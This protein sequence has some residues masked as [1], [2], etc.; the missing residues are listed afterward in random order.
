MNARLQ[1]GVPAL[2]P[3][4]CSRWSRLRM[5]IPAA[6][7]CGTTLTE[8]LIS[9]LVIGIGV[10]SV[11]TLFPLSL[12]RA[13]RATQLTAAA[14]VMQNALN[15]VQYSYFPD[16]GIEGRAMLF[17]PDNNGN[18]DRYG[19]V[20]A[21]GTPLDF[22]SGFVRGD[23]PWQTGGP[24]GSVRKY[25]VDP[26]GAVVLVDRANT[27]G[28]DNLVDTDGDGMDDFHPLIFG[29]LSDQDDVPLG[30]AIDGYS[31][32]F[33]WPA[34]GLTMEAM[35]TSAPAQELAIAQ[36]NRLVGKGGSYET[37]FDVTATV[38]LGQDLEMSNGTLIEFDPRDASGQA[39]ES[40]D[41]TDADDDTPV[42]GDGTAGGVPTEVVVYSDDGRSS[43]KLNV[44]AAQGSSL[45]AEDIPGEGFA[46]GGLRNLLMGAAADG[47]T[48]VRRVLLRVEEQRY[49][50]MLT[51]RRLGEGRS[52]AA[53][54]GDVVVFFNRS[55]S[56]EDE[57]VWKCE[58]D[59]DERGYVVSL[60]TRGRLPTLVAGTHFMDAETMSW[61]RIG[62]VDVRDG[63]TSAFFTLPELRRVRSESGTS[64]VLY[65]TFM[66][67]VV[68]VYPFQEV[69]D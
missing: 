1:Y 61:Y 8:V 16:A 38:T 7:R 24:V 13:A 58:Y 3:G 5:S 21:D 11:A 65:A 18:V 9:L 26:L 34:T 14:G 54:A 12:T 39:L 33:A 51:V 40:F 64:D 31:V 44:T 29:S 6:G 20:A 66:R 28:F 49:T 46:A 10:V 53:Y 27:A 36:A 45:L 63:G 4:E 32:R 48:A 59:A 30:A 35:A 69:S 60:G 41:P 17:D 25:V 42:D 62:Q 37:L 57:E 67:G 19:E 23:H 50:W 56:P 15:L 22:Y 52:T 2:D 55:L 43:L 68:D 47:T